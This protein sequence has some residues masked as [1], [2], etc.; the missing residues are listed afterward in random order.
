MTQQSL[1]DWEFLSEARCSSGL[2]DR[3]EIQQV[4]SSI[5]F[6]RHPLESTG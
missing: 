4:S 2:A 1:L 5:I 6:D 3:L